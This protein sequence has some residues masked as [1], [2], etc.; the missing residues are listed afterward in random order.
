MKFVIRAAS[1][2]GLAL[3]LLRAQVVRAAGNHQIS[4]ET[5]GA[6][7]STQVAKDAVSVVSALGASAG[8]AYRMGFAWT[9]F[10][11]YQILKSGSEVLLS[12]ATVGV[13]YALLGGQ[14]AAT[15]VKGDSIVEFDFPFRLGFMLAAAERSYNL[16]EVRKNSTISFEKLVP[17]KGNIVGVECGIS[18][19]IPLTDSMSV[20]GRATYMQPSFTDEPTQKGSIVGFGAGIGVAL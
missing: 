10:G 1:L 6:L 11:R 3:V 7:F 15:Q 4:T 13:D 16:S 19:E 17:K 14:S 20:L 18:L 12:G 9:V 8:Y 2:S 5:H